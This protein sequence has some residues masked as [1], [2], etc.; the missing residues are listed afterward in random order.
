MKYEKIVLTVLI[1]NAVIMS[2]SCKKFLEIDPPLENLTTKT[3]FESDDIAT[4][5]VTG[6]Y[7]RM[8]N[9]GGYASGGGN[10]ISSI[11]GLSSDEMITSQTL[12]AQFYENRISAENNT[13]LSN[14]LWLNPYQNIYTANSILEQLALS[15][16]LSPAVKSQLEGEAHFIRAFAYFYLVNLFGPVPL[17][18][19]SEY[20]INQKASRSPKND[21]YAQIIVDLKSAESL[22][23]DKYVTT[24]RIRPNQA[25]SQALLARTYLFLKDWGNAEK[26]ATLV[27]NK[28]AIYNLEPLDNIFLKNSKESIWQLMPGVG[29]TTSNTNEGSI[30]ILTATP[31]FGSL[32]TDLALNGFEVGDKRK[33]SWVKSFTNMTG[34]YYYPFKY[35]IKASTTPTEYSTVL[36]L[37]EQFLIR[38]EAR[39]QQENL[40]GAIDDLD[41]I[42]NRAGLKLIKIEN[43][44]INKANLL[45]TILKERYVELFS[46]WGHRWFDLK[47]TENANAVLGLLKTDWQPTDVLYPIPFEEVSRNSNIIQNLGY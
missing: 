12:V 15:T 41:A 24:E 23:S 35:K 26:Y 7:N 10:S 16:K 3:V 1:V 37:A 8:I 27:L 29:T 30:F 21:I 13:A 6:I 39:A 22:L 4:S 9:G 31:T 20:Q 42:R 18:L 33:S 32:R 47:R 25:A 5:A 40:L 44:G 14:S 2:F 11:C 45:N 43:P 38:A 46:E 34:T 28:T 36:R 19:T 17:H